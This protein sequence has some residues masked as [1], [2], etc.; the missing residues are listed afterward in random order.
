MLCVPDGKAAFKEGTS[1]YGVDTF[2]GL[3]YI[4]DLSKPEGE[5]VVKAEIN[6]TDI[7]GMDSIRVALN[8]YR[9]SGGYGF[10]EATGLSEADCFWTASTYLGSDMA[11]VPTQLGEYVKAMGVVTPDDEVSHGYESTWSTIF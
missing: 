6:G 9:L 10:A 3:D 7:K 5:R 1:I 4:F 8:S 2:Y 11:P